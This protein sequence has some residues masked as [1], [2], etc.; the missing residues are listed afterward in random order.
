MSIQVIKTNWRAH[1]DQLKEIRHRVFI[2]EQNV[3]EAME[4]EEADL[5]AQ[6]FL[7]MENQ[8]PIGT[9][10]LLAT[11]QVGR[12]AVL[13]PHRQQGIGNQ[14]IKACIATASQQ[15]FS[16]LYLHAQTSAI[17]F[18]KKYGF[19]LEGETFD[20]AGIAH[21]KMRLC[22]KQMERLAL[23]APASHQ[24]INDGLIATVAHRVLQGTQQVSL[25]CWDLNPPLLDNELC[26]EAFSS[27]L[28]KNRNTTAKI[29]IQDSSQLTR[30]GHRL[31]TLSRRLPSHLEIRK[32]SQD[33]SEVESFVLIV[34]GKGL[35]YKAHQDQTEYTV[36]RNA[37]T[38]A[39]E[40]GNLFENIWRHSEAD[41][42]LKALSL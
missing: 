16:G 19:Q 20:E 24:K 36:S 21:C 26:R 33:F 42:N 23:A 18:Y 27:F 8:R 32:I 2:E 13:K 4:W 10:R 12:M 17:D 39:T 14:L 41:P 5:H 11:G 25:L 31:L 1:G 38:M 29:L 30:N 9:A 40:Q 6:H 22:E 7:A 37:S 15:Q 34:D 28:R 3:P 35:I